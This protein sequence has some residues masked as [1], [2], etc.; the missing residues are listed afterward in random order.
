MIVRP[1]LQQLTG[2]TVL[3]NET[4]KR[5]FEEK[6]LVEVLNYIKALY[7]E[8]V[9][10]PMSTVIAYGAD[11]GTD[12]NWINQKYVA[13]FGYSST[14]ETLQAA[15]PDGNFAAG[16][17][18]VMTNAK[19]EGWYCNAP[20]YMCVSGASEHQ[21]EAMMFLNY[22]YNNADAAKILKTVRS[23][24]PTSVGQEACT[25]LGILEGITKDSVDII[26]T[27]TGT[28]DLG[29]TTEEEITAILQDAATQVAYG[30]GTPED[31]AKSTISLLDNYLSSK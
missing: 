16:K 6:D 24:P 2:S 14:V 18:P 5:G 11:L 10:S 12:P 17:L 28:N 9:A 29:L 22:F 8:G 26:Q 19:D 4:K 21:E 13:A 30:Q 3:V 15:C 20:Q 25:E 27:Y 1:Y 31:V 7:D 23:V